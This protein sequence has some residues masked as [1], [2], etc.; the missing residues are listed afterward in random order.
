[1]LCIASKN[2]GV[3]P[4]IED[5]AFILRESVGTVKKHLS[6]LTEAGLL[7]ASEQGLEPH[8]WQERQFKSDTSKERTR[9]YRERLKGVTS[10][11]SVTSHVTPPEQ[12]RADT[13]QS[14][15]S[16]DASHSTPAPE[17]INGKPKL[18]TKRRLREDFV[19]P[20]E[21]KDYAIKLGIPESECGAVWKKF[22]D[23]HLAKASAF[24]DWGAAWRTWVRNEIEFASRRRA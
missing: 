8:N 24:A 7:D 5:A 22:K 6:A 4:A 16:V 15:E 20:D 1:L 13:E 23:H 3:L 21:W 17:V 19:P 11:K 2:D 18:Q 10:D 14:R 9:A 12:S